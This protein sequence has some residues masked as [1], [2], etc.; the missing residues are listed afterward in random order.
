MFEKSVTC[1]Y[2]IELASSILVGGRSRGVIG[3]A[4]V[5]GE[6]YFIRVE[7]AWPNK[8]DDAKL[9]AP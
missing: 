5:A 2:N 1:M 4:A 7:G 8:L 9:E 3:T 6:G